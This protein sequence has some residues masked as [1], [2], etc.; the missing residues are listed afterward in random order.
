MPAFFSSVL[1]VIFVLVKTG[2]SPLACANSY[3]SPPQNIS[4]WRSINQPQS[5]SGPITATQRLR[6][7]PDRAATSMDMYLSKQR[8]SADNIA[9]YPRCGDSKLP[10]A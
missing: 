9:W 1:T 5:V 2:I 6:G 7:Q 10:G 3:R 4:L 8:I